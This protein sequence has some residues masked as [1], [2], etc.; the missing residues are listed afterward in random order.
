ME[1]F[2]TTRGSLYYFLPSLSSLRW[3]ADQPNAASDEC[4]TVCLVRV[5]GTT[6]WA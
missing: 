3:I 6:I 1:Q 5:S 2:V 4:S